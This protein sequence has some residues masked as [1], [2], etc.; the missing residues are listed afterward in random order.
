MPIEQML[1]WQAVTLTLALPQ[2]ISRPGVRVNCVICGEEIINER[3]VMVD[4]QTICR[5]CAGDAYYQMGDFVPS[6]AAMN[7]LLNEVLG[8]HVEMHHIGG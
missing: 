1:C 8:A 4:G 3:E 7:A 6:A 2:L 5:A